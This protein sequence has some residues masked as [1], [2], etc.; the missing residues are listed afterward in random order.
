MKDICK[1]CHGGGGL[2]AE[3]KIRDF[4][5]YM[6]ISIKSLIKGET[7]KLKKKKNTKHWSPATPSLHPTSLVK[8]TKHQYYKPKPR[9][10]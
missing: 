2:F 1:S 4:D 9:R 8:P 10:Q 3:D 5:L 6:V 7:G